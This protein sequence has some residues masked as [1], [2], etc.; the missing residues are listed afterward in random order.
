[1]KQKT[2]KAF[3]FTLDAFLASVLLVGTLM[4][5]S[6]INVHKQSTENLEFLSRDILATMA[7]I[8]I[9]E[10]RDTNGFVKQEIQSGN[11]T[12]LNNSVLEQI[13]EF[14]AKNQDTKARQ[15][16]HSVLKDIIPNGYGFNL[17]IGNDVVYNVSKGE[18]SS[19]ITSRRMISG[20]EKGKPLTGSTSDA[21][22]KT[23]RDKPSSVYLYFG[24]FVG[25][26]NITGQLFVPPIQNITDIVMELQAG[27]DFSLFINGNQCEESSGDTVFNPSAP[28]PDNKTSDFW[29]ITHCNASISK[30]GG[31]NNF[32]LTF[33]NVNGAYVAG[34]YI[35]LSYKTDE[36]RE[37]DYG[38]NRTRVYLPG[39]Y[40]IVNLFD[41]FYVPGELNNLTLRL[42]YLADHTISNYT[43]YAT[44]GNTIVYSDNDS[45][46]EMDVTLTDA[47]FSALDYDNFNSTTVPIR[48]G[49]ENVSFQQ[50]ITGGEGFGDIVL[51]T[52]NSGSMRWRFDVNNVDG[53]PR[54]CD[55]DMLYDD[56]TQ[57]ISVAKCT[58]KTFVND[59]LQNTTLN[60]IGLVAYN[61]ETSRIFPLSNNIADLEFEIDQYGAGSGTCIAC[62]VA[63]AYEMLRNPPP[64]QLHKDDDWKFTIDY[65][66]TAPPANW[67]EPWFNDASWETGATPFGYN[68]M[69]NT[70]IGDFFDANLWENDG[71]VPGAPADFTSGTLNFSGS[72][73][74]NFGNRNTLDG[75]D[76]NYGTYGGVGSGVTFTTPG[77][78]SN[79][80]GG[81]NMLR[82]RIA[83]HNG[84]Q[85]ASGAYGIEINV[86]PEM[87]NI[88]SSGGYAVFSF[89]YSWIGTSDAFE[90]QDEVW[91]KSRITNTT[92][93][94]AY[95]GYN[96]DFGH[97]GQPPISGSDPTNDIA[98][99]DNPDDD[100]EGYFSTM[101]TNYL[102]QPGMY[103]IDF[104]GKLLRSG[105][106]ENGYFYFDDIRFSVANKTGNTYYRNVFNLNGLSRFSNARLYVSS[107]DATEVYLNGNLLANDSSTPHAHTEWNINQSVG[108]GNFTDGANVLAVKL[109]NNDNVTG[110]FDLELRA[111]MAGRQKAIVIMSDGD[112]TACTAGWNGLGAGCWLSCTTGP[113]CPNSSD[114][115]T[116][117]L[118]GDHQPIG[119]SAEQAYNI[120]CHLFDQHNISLFSV[121]FGNVSADGRLTLN[122]SVSCD[123]SSHFYDYNNVSG[124]AE[125]YQDIADSIL[126]GFS[127][128]QSQIIV[129]TGDYEKSTLYPDSYI[130]FGYNPIVEEPHANEISLTFESP[131][132]SS[133]NPQIFI[134][135]GLRIIDSRITSFSGHHWTDFVGINSHE[136]FNLSHYNAVTY[137]SIGDPFA[138][139]IPS[140]LLIPGQLNNISL[141]TGDEPTVNTNCS[142]NNS[143]QYVGLINAST[144]RTLVLS[145]TEGCN[146]TIESEDGS[147]A[148]IL[149]PE[150]YEG[151]K[152]C[153]FT[154]AS[155]GGF[156]LDST[157]DFAVIELLRSL[158]FDEDG[159]TIINIEAANLEINVILVTGLPYQWGPS[160][161]QARLWR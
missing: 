85:I 129:T 33:P 127:S 101:I 21:F 49:F 146:W 137:I 3:L 81:N 35:K 36:F 126:T 74:D 16:A 48:I 79:A 80:N 11:I 10:I 30:T 150:N 103:Y 89:Y 50:I 38:T 5:F 95:L 14:W 19:E 32:T 66:F 123:N 31:F 37:L 111:D 106:D 130:E 13:G 70:I 77:Y 113:C 128:R 26:G 148:N 153:N 42:H 152:Q 100:F 4:L 63:S 133:C 88:I 7:K 134:P 93:G 149:V 46:T 59:V 156:D 47:N 12:N 2:K 55:S 104:G 75:W 132:F 98:A 102:T 94:I 144:G 56:S 155:I 23:V 58:D 161:V 97:L 157:Y 20:I 86:T 54:D 158:D 140:N 92:G 73:T 45:T 112:A 121:V 9:Y 41:S 145:D 52:D 122:L 62:G 6:S 136:V 57:R 71:D 22:L 72:F 17:T 138:V 67:Y 40:G 154:N 51:I 115:F 125:I 43:F 44:I 131:K 90:P 78:I 27:N 114:S 28:T 39:I 84:A 141:K 147:F 68:T 24:G 160:I 15:L 34:G 18:Y 8:K 96:A 142:F 118:C 135:E 76:G 151:A 65:Q 120:S 69:A 119:L 87:Y 60:R 29:D 99:R 105:N 53:D 108:M 117:N 109:F 25:Q 1:M 107:D 159:R 124:L 139:Q 110:Y 116:G 83:G 61:D 82:M 143:L 64:A 91:I